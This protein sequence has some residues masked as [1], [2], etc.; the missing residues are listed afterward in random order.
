M[1]AGVTHSV[2]PLLNQGNRLWIGQGDTFGALGFTKKDNPDAAFT[3]QPLH[4]DLRAGL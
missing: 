3:F 2:S 4:F 1:R